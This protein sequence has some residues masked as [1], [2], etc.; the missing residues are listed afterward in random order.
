MSA[1]SCV[2]YVVDE[3]YLFPTL[4][5]ALQARRHTPPVDAD[6]AICCLGA[7]PA[8]LEPF[9]KI[10]ES[11]GVRLLA[12][13]LSILDGRHVMFGRFF[14]DRILDRSYRTILYIDGDTQIARSLA[15][16]LTVAR[17]SGFIGAARDP[18]T[19]YAAMSDR[20]AGRHAAHC[21]AIGFTGAKADY[22]NSGVLLISPDGWSDI[23]AACLA[24]Y[25]RR[26]ERY[27]HPD[28]DVLNIV[29]QDHLHLMSTRWNFP[30]FLIGSGSEAAVSPHVYH[31]MS[32][33]RPWHSA[34][35]PWG[36][37]WAEPY[38]ELARRHP[39]LAAVAPRA[40]WSRRLRYAAQQRLK[41]VTEYRKVGRARPEPQTAVA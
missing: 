4:V 10:A 25:D 24:L 32:N 9:R 34:G 37:K 15:P 17:P 8:T 39:E 22:V 12:P 18:V 38:A 5:S 19:L 11:A 6:V 27:I 29:A 35:P 3:G 20:W 13:D 1:Q 14:L 30:G 7:P 2:C 23:S 28:Q 33:P 40:S 31:F 41:Q 16:L 26:P 36:V 21:D